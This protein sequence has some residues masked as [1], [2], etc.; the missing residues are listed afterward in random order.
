[1]ATKTG[2]KLPTYEELAAL[3]LETC[4][5]LDGA[6][7]P[8]RLRVELVSKFEGETCPTLEDIGGLFVYARDMREALTEALDEVG[9]IEATL[10]ELEYVRG[11][12]NLDP[13][14]A[15]CAACGK[16][17]THWRT[18]SDGWVWHHDQETG[19]RPFCDDC[20]D[21]LPAGGKKYPA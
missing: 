18:K 1:M 3:H 4:R 9:K 15:T 7:G 13:D 5:V 10:M 8:V 19:F 20:R 12:N 17:A 11:E 6:T 16:T 2:G 14:R 21:K